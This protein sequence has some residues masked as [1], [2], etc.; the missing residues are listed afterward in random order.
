MENKS[1][2][3]LLL[4]FR[5]FITGRIWWIFFKI[6]CRQVFRKEWLL[7]IKRKL[8]GTWM[9]FLPPPTEIFSDERQGYLRTVKASQEMSPFIHYAT[10]TV[11]SACFREAGVTE[12]K[13]KIATDH[14]AS[15]R[16]RDVSAGVPPQKQMAHTIFLV[17]IRFLHLIY[18]PSNHQMAAEDGKSKE[19]P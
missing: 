5:F 2:C 9:S 14:N 16:Q 8:R 10:S 17:N 12:S 1:A 13:W 7:V 6:H 3:S 19:I 4:G 18:S 15:R 11:R